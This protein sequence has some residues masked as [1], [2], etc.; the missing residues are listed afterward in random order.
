MSVTTAPLKKVIENLTL[1]EKIGIAN[2]PEGKGD[3][4]KKKLYLINSTYTSSHNHV[5]YVIWYLQMT[6]AENKNG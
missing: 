4:C 1:S 5:W 3:L 2:I 6:G